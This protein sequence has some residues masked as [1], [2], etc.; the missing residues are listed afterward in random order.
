MPGSNNV[1]MLQVHMNK[2]DMDITFPNQLFINNEF[3]NSSDGNT[4]NTVNP[5]DETVRYLTYCLSCIK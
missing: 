3:I 1:F 4:F 2:N 5:A